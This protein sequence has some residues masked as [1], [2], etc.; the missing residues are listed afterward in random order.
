MNAPARRFALG[1]YTP[2]GPAAGLHLAERSASGDWRIVASAT[3]TNPSFVARSEAALTRWSLARIDAVIQRLANAVL[4]G[5]RSGA[6]GEVIARRTL[7]AV[8][9]E[10]RRR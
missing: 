6:F 8:A 5:R 2:D 10:A 4:E 7:A 9:S 1:S 3:T